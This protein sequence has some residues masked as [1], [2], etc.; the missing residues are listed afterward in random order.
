M[1]YV[2]C[3]YCILCI[4]FGGV[5]DHLVLLLLIKFDLIWFDCGLRKNIVL[6]KR[7]HRYT[8]RS[9]QNILSLHCSCWYGPTDPKNGQDVLP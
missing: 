8:E 4:M 3:F 6:D 2:I 7:T 9:E 5:S 1:Y